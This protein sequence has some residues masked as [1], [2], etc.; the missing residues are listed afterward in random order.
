VVHPKAAHGRDF[1]PFN[2]DRLAGKRAAGQGMA[3]SMHKT[4][5]IYRNYSKRTQSRAVGATLRR[6]AHRRTNAP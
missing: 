4:A 2:K 5:R 6:L 1:L 3:L